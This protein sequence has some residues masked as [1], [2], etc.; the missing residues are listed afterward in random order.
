MLERVVQSLY[1]DAIRVSPPTLYLISYDNRL[2]AFYH[3]RNVIILVGETFFFH[4]N[5][6]SL[7]TFTLQSSHHLVF[8]NNW[9]N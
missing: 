3:L 7:L 5:V 1:E 8:V 2:I 9:Q 6:T 4:E